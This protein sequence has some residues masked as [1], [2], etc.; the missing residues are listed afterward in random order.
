M[1]VTRSARKKPREAAAPYAKQ[2]PVRSARKT[3]RAR[4]MQSEREVE[5]SVPSTPA[6]VEEQQVQVQAQAQASPQPTACG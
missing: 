6:E 5:P 4:E 1:P 3:V 2:R